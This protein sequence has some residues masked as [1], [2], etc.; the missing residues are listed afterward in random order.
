MRFSALRN[1]TVSWITVSSDDS[2]G[3]YVITCRQGDD[4]LQSFN[5]TFLDADEIQSPRCDVFPYDI[6]G[7]K[8]YTTNV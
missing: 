7:V 5:L 3:N 6:F 8:L 2:Q 4:V 1:T